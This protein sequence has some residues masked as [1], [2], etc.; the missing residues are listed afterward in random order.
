M[1]TTAAQWAA[2]TMSIAQQR[3]EL[4]ADNLANLSTH[5]FRRRDAEVQR[6]SGALR[7]AART[8][9]DQG[10]IRPTGNRFDLAL[11]G[12]GA[13]ALQTAQGAVIH[14]RDG[15]FS[16]TE[17]GRLLDERGRAL[18]GRCGV[19][20]V[21]AQAVIDADGTV[22]EGERV[23]D[24]LALPHGTTVRQGAIE[25]SGVEATHELLAILRAQRSFES[26]QRIVA[27]D[28]EMHRKAIDDVAQVR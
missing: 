4:A 12:H 27:A 14:S 15:A 18:M 10:A 16:R 25:V 22:R 7:L 26:G 3:L 20:H 5:G 8:V 19:L 17:D 13:F 24:L 6:F 11:A 21:G 28:D 9:Q 1:S 23:V 2:Q